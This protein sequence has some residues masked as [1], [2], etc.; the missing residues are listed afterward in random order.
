LSEK[1]EYSVADPATFEAVVCLP[2]PAS[3]EGT[4]SSGCKSPSASSG[5]LLVWL[6]DRVGLKWNLLWLD[7]TKLPSEPPCGKLGW[8]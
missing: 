1:L 5:Y 8:L 6:L 4:L 7:P 3:F 2:F